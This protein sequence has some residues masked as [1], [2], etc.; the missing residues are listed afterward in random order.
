MKR[1]ERWVFILVL[2]HG[3]LLIGVQW[4]ILHTDFALYVHPVYEYFG[5]SQQSKSKVIETIDRV[6]Q[7]VLSF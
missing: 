7:T 5:V 1:I 2:F 3:I 4:V 6:F